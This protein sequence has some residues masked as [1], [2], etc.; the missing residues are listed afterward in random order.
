LELQIIGRTD[1]TGT[2][3]QNQFIARERAARVAQSLAAYDVPMPGFSLRGI[4]VAPNHEGRND[5]MR[6][7]EFRVLGVEQLTYLPDIKE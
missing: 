4:P 6:R 5:K 3:Q 1:G 7:V 2:P